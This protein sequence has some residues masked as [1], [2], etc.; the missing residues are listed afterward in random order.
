MLSLF[1]L[2]VGNP[3]PVIKRASIPESRVQVTYDLSFDSWKKLFNVV[4][5]LTVQDLFPRVLS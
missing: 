1:S 2:S 4:F 3:T 5:Q